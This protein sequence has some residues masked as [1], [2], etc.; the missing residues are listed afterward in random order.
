[1]TAEPTNPTPTPPTRT[2]RLYE[3]WLDTV[4]I[5]D[6]AISLALTTALTLGGYI[7]APGP[8]PQPLVFGL[9]GSLIGFVISTVTFRPKRE[10]VID[11][12]PAP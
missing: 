2:N 12:E 6:L 1:M 10:L 11:D 4:S 3:V 9:V 5:R 7:V 8:A